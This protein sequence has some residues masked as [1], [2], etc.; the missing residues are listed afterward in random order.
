MGNAVFYAAVLGECIVICFFFLDK[1]EI[2][3]LGFL[4][5]NVVGAV[6][7]VILSLVLDKILPQQPI[8]TIA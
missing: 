3:G 6:A 2:V 8:K 7:V 1:Y 4:W 5:L